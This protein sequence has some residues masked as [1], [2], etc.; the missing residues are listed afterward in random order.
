MKKESAGLPESVGDPD[1]D[2]PLSSGVR[3]SE[4]GKAELDVRRC[5]HPVIPDF[6]NGEHELIKSPWML[7]GINQ[8]SDS[9][10]WMVLP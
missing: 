9:A 1:W 8:F 5:T 7:R 10:W 4:A 6:E 3:M 2:H